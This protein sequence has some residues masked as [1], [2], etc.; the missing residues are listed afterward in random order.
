MEGGGRG[1]AI[2]INF[3]TLYFLNA[4][5][6]FFVLILLSITRVSAGVFAYLKKI[7][8]YIHF[9]FNFDNDKCAAPLPPP[10]ALI[11]AV[12]ERAVGIARYIHIEQCHSMC[13]WHAVRSKSC[14]IIID[15]ITVTNKQISS[16][17]RLNEISFLW[18]LQ[19]YFANMW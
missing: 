4:L 3:R 10:A 16:F 9:V 11:F 8:M 17:F 18:V 14:T 6:T 2:Y 1:V 5:Y 15:V 19:V 7:Y 12:G 13:G